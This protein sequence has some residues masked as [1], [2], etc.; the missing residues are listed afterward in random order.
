MRS[1]IFAAGLL[2]ASTYEHPVNTSSRV[3]ITGSS[4]QSEEDSLRSKGLRQWPEFGYVWAA[5]KKAAMK[6]H[7]AKC[8]TLNTFKQ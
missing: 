4:D 6:K 8:T 1:L 3:S 5:T 2:A 7:K